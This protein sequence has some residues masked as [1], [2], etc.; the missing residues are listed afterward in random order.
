M[1][2]PTIFQIAALMGDQCDGNVVA[3]HFANDHQS[4]TVALEGVLEYAYDSLIENRHLNQ[5]QSEDALS[6]QIVAY[7]K[8][9]GVQASHDTQTGGHCDVHVVCKDHFLWIGE[10][11][12]HK[13][14]AWLESGFK[15]LSTRYGTGSYGQSQGEIIIYCRSR[16][17]AGTL[18]TWKDHMIEVFPDVNVIEDLISTRLWFRTVHSCVTSGNPFSTRH[19]IINLHWAGAAKKQKPT[20]KRQSSSSNR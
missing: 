7:L 10:A 13:D 8:A 2:E 9:L 20:P 4:R 11:K 5:T 19:R 6:V 16:D 15:Q 17:A 14:Y 1:P 18:S 3:F 12:I